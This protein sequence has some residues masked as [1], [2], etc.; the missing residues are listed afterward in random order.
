M[1]YS[2]LSDAEINAAVAKRFPDRFMFNDEG[3][4]YSL[5]SD[6]M[7]AYS[8]SDFDEVEFDP[9]NNPADAWPIIFEKGIG[10]RKQSNGVWSVTQPGGKWPQ[11]SD[12]PLRA[13]MIVFLMMQESE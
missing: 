4:P 11:Y 6:S 9:C 8:G 5:E 3:I 1:D 12:K 7:A 2:K 10:L 13:A